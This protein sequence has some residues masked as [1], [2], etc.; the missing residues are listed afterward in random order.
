MGV[1]SS[2]VR[3]P[4]GLLAF[5]LA[6]AL[7]LI[8]RRAVGIQDCGL[9]GII[10]AIH[11][12]GEI[13]TRHPPLATKQRGGLGI[14]IMTKCLPFVDCLASSSLD[15][16]GLSGLNLPP[17]HLPGRSFHWQT[18]RQCRRLTPLKERAA[19]RLPPNLSSVYALRPVIAGKR[20]GTTGFGFG[21]PRVSERLCPGFSFHPHCHQPN[22][23][24]EAGAGVQW[25]LMV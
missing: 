11:A 15:R 9:L 16:Q 4:R 3:L 1:D 25:L 20:R 19:P 17:Q 22:R 12:D 2:L 10:K 21:P 13:K 14:F 5:L 6:L 7:E 24:Q 8:K 23:P 18:P